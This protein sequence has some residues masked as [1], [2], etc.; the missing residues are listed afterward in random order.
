MCIILCQDQSEHTDSES[1][2]I[3]GSEELNFVMKNMKEVDI[4]I[5]DT[6]G[7]CDSSQSVWFM[8]FKYSCL[9]AVFSWGINDVTTYIFSGWAAV[10]QRE[11]VLR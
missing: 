10:R 1:F 11:Q 8:I 4:G 2:E 5:L 7:G 9:E 6:G 3:I